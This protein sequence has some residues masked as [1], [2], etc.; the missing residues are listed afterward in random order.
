[1]AILRAAIIAS[2]YIYDRGKLPDH[3]VPSKTARSD[4]KTKLRAVFL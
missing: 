4:A 1:M 2:Q 3:I